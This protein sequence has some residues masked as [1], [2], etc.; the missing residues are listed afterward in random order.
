M[1]IRS[2]RLTTASI[3]SQMTVFIV[4]AL[5][6]AHVLL[7]GAVLF[8]RPDLVLGNPSSV[9]VGRI[10]ALTVVFEGQ[11]SD[12]REAALAVARK[13][14]PDARLMTPDDT[15][16][17]SVLD[18]AS[19]AIRAAVQ[20]LLEGRATVSFVRLKS[21]PEDE[22]SLAVALSSGV[23]LVVPLLSRDRRPPLAP[24]LLLAGA[25]A[26]TL[27]ALS[28]WAARQLPA[29]LR[30]FSLA[31]ERFGRS[32]SD[33]P[34][35][36]SGPLEIRRAATAFNG[37]RERVRR[38]V[39]DRTHMLAAIS[40]DLRTPLTRL[41]LRI[42]TLEDAEM[43]AQAL[44]DVRAMEAMLHS[45]LDYLRVEGAGSKREP[46]DV[47][48]LL[49]TVC[50]DFAD[51]GKS[52]FY[53]GPPHA[54]MTGDHDLLTRAVTNLVENATRHGQWV[55]LRLRLPSVDLIEIEVEDDGPGMSD[56]L[57]QIALQPFVRGDE[58]RSSQGSGNF[59][60]GL[61]IVRTVVEGHGGAVK[62]RDAQPRGLIAVLRLPARKSHET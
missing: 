25:I 46:L 36:E 28:I 20:V 11:P 2:W 41:G 58:A 29:P 44:A 49:Q 50:D 14:Q 32:L 5:V 9:F 47:A 33:E 56:S 61:S 15:I 38:M 53:D 24:L 8:G 4:G 27:I 45:G 6:L 39:E 3:A 55:V 31:A 12:D 54:P 17:T 16:S 52:I 26:V 60:L 43:R 18:P 19:L 57:K 48:T 62:L 42:E 10:V 13:I 30:R 22:A 35:P 23:M 1:S 7:L 37:M 34:L 21:A 40:H 51:L 59:G